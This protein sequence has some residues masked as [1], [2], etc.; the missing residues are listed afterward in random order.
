M[1]RGGG[2]HRWIRQREIRGVLVE[3]DRWGGGHMDRCINGYMKRRRQKDTY[4]EKVK[5]VSMPMGCI[6]LDWSGVGLCSAHPLVVLSPGLSKLYFRGT[7]FLRNY[8]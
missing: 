2:E 8:F 4:R 3:I 5:E 6:G 1:L 7:F